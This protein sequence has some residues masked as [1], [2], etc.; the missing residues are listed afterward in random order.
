MTKIRPEVVNRRIESFEKRFGQAH[1][2]L[3]YH[4]AFPIAL[5]P[6]LLYRLWANFQRDIHGAVL[7]IPWIAVADLLLSSL[8]DEVGHELYEMDLALRNVLLSRLQEDKNFGQQRINELSE[9]LL[10][11]VRQK[12]KSDDPDT[13]EFA[14]AQHWIAL[15]YTRPTQVAHELALAFSKLDL[16]DKAN[17]VRLASLTETFA[18][19][20]AEFQPLLIYARGMAKFAR[21]GNLTDAEPQ[22]DELV[23]GGKQIQVAGV[24]LLLPEQIRSSPTTP[25]PLQ[26]FQF[27]VVTVNVRG[28]ITKRRNCQANYFV[29]NVGNGA[30][31][32]MVQIPG[33][34]FT[35]GSPTTEAQRLD[36]EGPQHQVTVP[37]FF[38]G[39]YEVTQAQYQAIMGN[40]PSCFKGETR[41]VEQV[42]WDEAIEF[43]K[44]LS[45]KTGRTYRL[46]SEAEWEYACRAGTTTP[47]YFGETIITDLANYYGHYTYASAPK[48]QYRQQTTNIGQFPPNSFGLYDM[49]GNVWEWCLDIY[50]NNYNRVP[51]DGSAWVSEN[52]H[53]SRIMRG[54]SWDSYPRK[55]RCAYRVRNARAD[56]GND[57]G[58]R[59]VCAVV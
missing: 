22:F 24:S 19:P 4:A 29:E 2:Y 39:K 40:N 36:N 59:L 48:G 41:P 34:T 25:K 15:A 5:T 37:M 21:A 7:N 14:Q 44:K 27:E 38:M 18:E 43:C 49:H 56:R 12:L 1:L 6:D 16:K 52:D 13:Q 46:P 17:L 33:G 28:T 3:A 45:Q 57:V 31:L 42:S 51:T 50:N 58:F 32:E 9:F 20:L 55:C 54:G 8:C 10:D 23:E 35:M 53:D 47:F 30:T 26:T 11:Y